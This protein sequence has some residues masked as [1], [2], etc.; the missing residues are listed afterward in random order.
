ML[1]F[2][3]CAWHQ[4]CVSSGLAK[5][6]AQHMCTPFCPSGGALMQHNNMQ[7]GWLTDPE[8]SLG[9]AKQLVR[10]LHEA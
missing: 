8:L 10:H 3:P 6:T 2:L 9:V 4:V 1:T 7:T 5:H